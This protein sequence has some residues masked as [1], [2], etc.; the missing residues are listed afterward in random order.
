MHVPS[1]W[2]RIQF[3]WHMNLKKTQ[4]NAIVENMGAFD[5]YQFHTLTINGLKVM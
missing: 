5:R 1:A 3:A 4:N 2:V